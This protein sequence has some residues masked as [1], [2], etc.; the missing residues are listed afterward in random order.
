M[1]EFGQ[2][3][4][5]AVEHHE[6]LLKAYLGGRRTRRFAGSGALCWRAVGLEQRALK[7]EAS[8]SKPSYILRFDL[9][10]RLS[11]GTNPAG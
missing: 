6:C 7:G 8:T 9:G 11:A 3:T 5:V 1:F 4:S 10:G 2:P